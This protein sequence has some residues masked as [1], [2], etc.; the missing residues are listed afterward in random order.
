MFSIPTAPAPAIP[1]QSHPINPTPLSLFVP[2]SKRGVGFYVCFGIFGGAGAVGD[3]V[4]VGVQREGLEVVQRVGEG[5]G[6][7]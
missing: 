7:R 6:E 5:S 1:S 3:G 2:Q 4:W